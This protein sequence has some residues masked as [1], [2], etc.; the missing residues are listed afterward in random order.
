MAWDVV[1]SH[2]EL[3]LLMEAGL[4]YR[5]AK[6]FQEAR[7]VFGGVRAL[8]PQDGQ[9][10]HLAKPELPGLRRV[11]SQFR[12]EDLLNPKRLDDIVSKS[13]DELIEVEFQP[14]AQLSPA[15]H[16]HLAEWMGNDPILRAKIVK[17]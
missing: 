14:A 15:D 4:I 6:K 1:A 16:K 5:D 11:V 10:N 7:E 9:A 17:Y 13:V 3:A 8:V 12:R 2:D